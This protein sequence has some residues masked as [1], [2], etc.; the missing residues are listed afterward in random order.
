MILKLNSEERNKMTI[1]AKKISPDGD[2][3]PVV[4]EDDPKDID[5][6]NAFGGQEPIS[7]KMWVGAWEIL[8]VSE[9]EDV[10]VIGKPPPMGE[11][12]PRR[13]TCYLTD[14]QA[15]A[16]VKAVNWVLKRTT[17]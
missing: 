8:V 1:D 5:L 2:V 14:K 9:S 6:I 17:S 16:L 11:P 4:L 13:Q 10:L 7:V 12:E 15:Y 3:T